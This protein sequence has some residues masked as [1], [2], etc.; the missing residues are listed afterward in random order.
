MLVAFSSQ[1]PSVVRLKPLSSKVCGELVAQSGAL[2]LKSR[3]RDSHSRGDIDERH[4]VAQ[5]TEL[6]D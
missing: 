6:S 4:S 3:L 5:V 2:S 1:L